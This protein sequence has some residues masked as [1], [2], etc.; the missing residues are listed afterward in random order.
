MS[1]ATLGLAILGEMSLGHSKLTDDI[2]SD[3]A[4]RMMNYLPLYWHDVLEMSQILSS[5][6]YEF[7]LMT[8][9]VKNVLKDAFIMSASEERLAQWE[10]TLK[11]APVG[12]LYDRRMAILQYFTTNSKLSATVIK[13]S[14]SSLYNNARVKVDFNDSTINVLIIPLPEHFLDELDFSILEKQLEYRKPCHIGLRITR[15]YSKW[16][17]VKNDFQTWGDAKN[18]FKDWEWVYLYIPE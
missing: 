13:R 18:N 11:L 16:G 12:T 17:D 2:A 3:T 4:N 10:N 15:G 5:E 8:E 9:E 7:E 1:V 6:G 14:A